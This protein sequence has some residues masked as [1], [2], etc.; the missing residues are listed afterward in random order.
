[1][2][3]STFPNGVS[4]GDATQTEAV[5][6]ARSSVP[7]PVEFTISTSPDFPRLSG[8]DGER[9]GPSRSRKGADR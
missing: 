1:M 3:T 4:A 6:W 5:L 9:G 7:G 8:A 2:P